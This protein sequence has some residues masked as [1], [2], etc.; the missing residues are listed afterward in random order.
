MDQAAFKTFFDSCLV[1]IETEWCIAR[2]DLKDAVKDLIKEV[3]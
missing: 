3:K 2:E 1:V